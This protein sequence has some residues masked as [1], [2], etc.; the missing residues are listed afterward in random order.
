MARDKWIWVDTTETGFVAVAAFAF[1]KPTTHLFTS[2]SNINVGHLK[3]ML[4]CNSHLD[5]FDYGHHR[6]GMQFKTFAECYGYA[7]NF[8]FHSIWIFC[9]ENDRKKRDRASEQARGKGKED[10][11]FQTRWKVLVGFLF[12]Q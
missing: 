9:N 7:P 12:T 5:R 11:K 3:C 1:V 6:Y 2:T 8:F 10:K 4:V